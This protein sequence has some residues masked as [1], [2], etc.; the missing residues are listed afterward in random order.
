M[1]GLVPI[2]GHSRKF[3]AGIFPRKISKPVIDP[4]YIFNFNDD[5]LAQNHHNDDHNN[6]NYDYYNHNDHYD[7]NNYYYN[8]YHDT[9]IYWRDY[10]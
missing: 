1:T 9:T 10:L 3:L 6:N 7:Y 8:D 5:I 4:L 2:P